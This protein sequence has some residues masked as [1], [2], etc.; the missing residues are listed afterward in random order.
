MNANDNFRNHE[1]GDTTD[2]AIAILKLNESVEILNSLIRSSIGTKPVYSVKDLAFLL[3]KSEDSIYKLSRQMPNPLPLRELTGTKR[4]K[5]VIHDEFMA[6]F[7][8]ATRLV[9]DAS[10]N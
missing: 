4:G 6:W 10:K 3:G 8:R 9:P 5:Y 7:D 1:S 2:L